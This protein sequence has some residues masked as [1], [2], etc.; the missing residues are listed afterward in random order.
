MNQTP[1]K[2]FLAEQRGLLETSE[3]RRYSTFSF[4]PYVHAHK[5]PLDSLYGVNE[6]MLAGGTAT[7]LAVPTDSYVLLLPI[8]GAVTAQTA[9]A[10]A[11]TTVDV[12]QVQ[13]SRVPA[14]TT[15]H[16][17]N[18]YTAEVVRYVQLF[19]TAAQPVTTAAEQ[20]FSFS[21]A[22]IE[23]QLATLLPPA[24]GRPFGVHLGRFSGRREV[25]YTLRNEASRF[26]ALVLAGAFEV[27]GRL[28]HAGDGLALWDVAAVE[29][30]ALSNG[31]IVLVVEQYAA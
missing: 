14:H 1:G 25:V 20:V 11:P 6:E 13:L 9:A 29:L 24:A 16:L 19:L 27:E 4:G 17:T 31:A 30:E 3:V 26:F 23:N 8:T 15:L 2:I 18:P 22:A 7:S 28:L 10:A 21:F 5:Q 12:E